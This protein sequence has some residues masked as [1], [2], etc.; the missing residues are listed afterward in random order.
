[1][2][3][4]TNEALDGQR[5]IWTIGDYPA[6]A[7]HLRPISLEVLDTVG[8]T[9]G[10]RVLD[11]GVGDGNTAIEAAAR[12]AVVAGIDLTPAQIER[13]RRR[14]GSEGVSLDLR[15]G[16][17]E[18]LPYDDASFDLV[19]SVLGAMFAPDHQRAAAELARVCRP[20][21]TVAFVAWAEGGWSRAWRARAATLLPPPPAGSPRPDEWGDA[22]EA[23]RRLTAAGLE[24][25]AEVRPFH[26]S[27]P[28]A[29]AALDL[30]LASAGPFIAFREAAAQAGVGD[31]V[32]PELLA[33][34][35]EANEA[36]NGACL[37][38]APYLLAVG[39]RPSG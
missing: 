18:D 29:R 33:A 39:A 24:V 35:D 11:V 19:V 13:A 7:R 9:P 20:G 22:D 28:S 17:A 2:T 31:R 15:V 27:F 8:V 38:A 12:G 14:A 3:E 36:T 4:A 21:G 6:I 26:W 25:Q 16:D 37:L 1:M 34:L 10:L 5:R 30:F 32:E 23:V